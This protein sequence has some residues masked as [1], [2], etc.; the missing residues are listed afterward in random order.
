MKI[1]SLRCFRIFFFFFFHKI[2]NLNTSLWALENDFYTISYLFEYGV[3]KNESINGIVWQFDHLISLSA[4]ENVY[5]LQITIRL[6]YN[7][8]SC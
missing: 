6:N 4:S 5:F 8:K 7:E 3:V 2:Y 1:Y